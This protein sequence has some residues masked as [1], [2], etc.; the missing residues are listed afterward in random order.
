M[1]ALHEMY[2]ASRLLMGE[3]PYKEYIPGTEE[4]HVLKKKHVYETYWE[5]QCH[6]HIC[7]QIT[8]LRAGGVKQ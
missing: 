4:L 3:M 2:E 6:L 1:F 8:A 5:L 7:A